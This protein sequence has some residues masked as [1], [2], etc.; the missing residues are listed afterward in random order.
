MLNSKPSRKDWQGLHREQQRPGRELHKRGEFKHA[1]TIKNEK[2]NNQNQNNRKSKTKQGSTAENIA[3]LT[4]KDS[5]LESRN[6]KLRRKGKTKFQR[7]DKIVL[8]N[9]QKMWPAK[10]DWRDDRGKK[11]KN[12]NCT[13][14]KKEDTET[15]RGKKVKK[16]KKG[17]RNE[18]RKNIDKKKR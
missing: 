17:N 4:G 13:S 5:G 8:N 3:R 2:R 18:G 16:K 9:T 12:K 14:E 6:K 1:D 11:G 7:E 15:K 10:Q